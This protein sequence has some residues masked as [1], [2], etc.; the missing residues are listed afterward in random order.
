[1][2]TVVDAYWAA[3]AVARTVA[4]L[5]FVCSLGVYT[6]MFSSGPFWFH[7]RFLFKFPPAVYRLVTSFLITGPQ[8]GVLLDTYFV[9]SYLSQLEKSNSKFTRK[10]DLIWYLM[11]VGSVIIFLNQTIVGAG[12]YL[13]ALL[14]AICYTATQDQRGQMAHF[15]VVTI[16]AQLMPYALLLLNLLNGWFMVKVGLTG[17]VAAHFHDFCTRLYPQ[18]GGGPNLL[19]T[20]WW[21]SWLMS[22]PRVSNTSY[23]SAFVPPSGGQSRGGPLPDSWRSAGPGRRLG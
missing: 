23:G 9:Y 19:P 11:V 2:S 16:P 12:S 8:I 1:M 15:Y 14:I 10:E 21:I 7:W 22:T 17:L 6:E 4:T 3:P 18:F 5:V 13:P 20:P